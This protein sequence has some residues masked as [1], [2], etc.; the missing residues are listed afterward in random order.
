MDGSWT[1]LEELPVLHNDYPLTP[2]KLEINK[3]M[4]PDYQ[5]KNVDEYKML[6]SFKK[7]APNFIDKEK[8]VLKYTNFQLYLKLALKTKNVHQVSQFD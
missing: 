3:E 6:V 2:D 5:F 7:I 8:Q 1:S 4:L